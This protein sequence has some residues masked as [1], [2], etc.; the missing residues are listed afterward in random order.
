LSRFQSRVEFNLAKRPFLDTRRL[1]LAAATMLALG[2]VLGWYNVKS[3]IAERRQGI[4]AERVANQEQA[5]GRLQS[6][7]ETAR[8]TTEAA[9]TSETQKEIDFLNGLINERT[10]SWIR[11]LSRLERALPDD[12]ALD[13][14]RPTFRPRDT[15][16]ELDLRGV[17]PSADGMYR[18]IENLYADPS[19]SYPT[20]RSDQD[21]EKAGNPEGHEF[22]IRVFY[23]PARAANTPLPAARKAVSEAE[24]FSAPGSVTMPVKIEP[25]VRKAAVAAPLPPAAVIQPPISN[26]PAANPAAPSPAPR[27]PLESRG[28][29]ASAAPVFAAPLS[30]AT[31]GSASTSATPPGAPG[32]AMPKLRPGGPS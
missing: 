25:P 14:I 15:L 4:G 1:N 7:I 13:S 10:F 26:P 31:A 5:I 18:F 3:W 22:V 20:P 12:A 24:E 11:M 23:D 8:Q 30:P 6:E 21:Q 29:R 27:S 9:L 2:F 17:S 32:R 19:F 28:N 16:V